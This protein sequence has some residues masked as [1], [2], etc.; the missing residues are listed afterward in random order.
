MEGRGRRSPIPADT[1]FGHRMRERR[2]MLG[3]SQTELGAALGVTFQ[4]IQKYERG[5]NRVSAGTMQK[6]AATLRVPIAYFFDSPPAEIDQTR[7]VEGQ[8]ESLRL[9]EI[10]TLLI[11]EGNLESLY[12]RVL[13]AAIDLMSAHTGSLQS[14][15]PEQ[16]ELRLLVWK[17]FHPDSAAFWERVHL[18][19]ASTCGAALSVGHRVMVPDVEACDFMAGTADLDAYRQ[20]GIRAVQS[21]PLVSR[22]GRLLGMISTH[23][24]EP[25]QPTERAF[26]LFDVLARQAADLVERIQVETALRE[27]EQRSRW[28]ASIVESSDDAIVSKDSA[29]IITTWNKGA[30]RLFGYMADEVVGKPI[31]ILIPP[32]R[33]SEE[34][35]ILDCIN[36]GGRI[37]NY[38]TVRQCK[39][40]S[41]VN[42]SLTVSSVKNAEGKI[43]GASKIARDIT[44]RKRAEGR[45]KMLMTE[46][47]HRVRNALARVA[48]LAASSRRDNG[49]ID[50]FARS[51]D[52][53]IHSM[54]AAHTLLSQRGG[55]GVGLG[56]LVHSQLAPYAVEANITIRGTE[57]MLSPVAIQAMGMVLHELVTNAAKYGA[58]SVPTGQVSVSWERGRN[59]SA[60][61]NLIFVWREFGGPRTAAEVK[62][63]YGIRLIRELVPYE[64]GG[65]VDLVFAS[66]GVSCRIEVPLRKSE[67]AITEYQSA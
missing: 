19:S 56:A 47:D 45:E 21:T 58:L 10:S 63:G 49:S 5:V 28:L 43:V 25:H 60:A 9:Q 2:M 46:L 66:E 54:A 59:G 16:R 64:L 13:D 35:A 40:G 62:P 14:F 20:S 61:A 31:T 7:I 22:S 30:E 12:R 27:S 18:E 57:L 50:E 29:G 53:R 36:R 38:E 23:W 55:H 32:D 44:R 41:L 42:V 3:M 24:L 67:A 65:A 48:M 17:G 1:R 4:Q 15:S 26:R 8:D 11:E 51:L 52:G 39:D 34:R 6:L 33:H 37:E